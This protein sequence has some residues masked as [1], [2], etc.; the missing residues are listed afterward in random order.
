MYGNRGSIP[1]RKGSS[2]GII[3]LVVIIVILFT[4]GGLGLATNGFAPSGKSSNLQTPASPPSSPTPPPSIQPPA[5]PPPPEQPPPVVTPPPAPTPQVIEI[6]AASL[7]S[8]YTADPTAAAGQYE[9]KTC[10]ITGKVSRY[11]L[12]IPQYVILT[13]DTADIIKIE[14]K[15]QFNPE[16]SVIPFYLKQTVTIEGKIAPF[17]GNIIASECK[18]VR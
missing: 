11:S 8:S 17:T 10:S 12:E 1:Q 15:F 13:G 5:T 6:T 16:A 3:V 4:I 2:G 18:F 7:I 14:C 9:G